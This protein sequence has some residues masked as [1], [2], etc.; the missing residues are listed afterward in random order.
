MVI[1]QGPAVRGQATLGAGGVRWEEAHLVIPDDGGWA[2]P[3]DVRLE[4]TDVVP[5]VEGFLACPI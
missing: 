5:G 2:P 1:Q 4:V 3:I